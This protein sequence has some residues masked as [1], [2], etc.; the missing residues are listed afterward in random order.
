ML[1]AIRNQLKD[2]ARKLHRPDLAKVFVH[3]DKA[4]VGFPLVCHF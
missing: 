2:Q 3:P 4:R 1:S